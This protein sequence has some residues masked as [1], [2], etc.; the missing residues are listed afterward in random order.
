QRHAEIDAKGKVTATP[1]LKDALLK[2]FLRSIS[3]LTHHRKLGV[4]LLHLSPAFSPRKHEL[5]ELEPLIQQL[6]D[7]RLVIEFRNRNWVVGDQL[8]S[9]IEFLRDRRVAFVN[10]D[11][12]NDE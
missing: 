2:E 7:Y 4:L 3:I 9:T 12:P 8:Q 6:P 11:A 10:V 5:S 1:D